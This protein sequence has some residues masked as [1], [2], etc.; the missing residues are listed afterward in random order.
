MC[1]FAYLSVHVHVSLSFVNIPGMY[2]SYSHGLLCAQGPCHQTTL[3]VLHNT[4][5]WQIP[6]TRNVHRTHYLACD[7]LW[8]VFLKDHDLSSTGVSLYF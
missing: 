6:V 3:P 7:S 4:A 5:P 2:H 8:F 1:A